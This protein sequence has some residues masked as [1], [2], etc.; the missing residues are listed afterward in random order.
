MPRKAPVR[1]RTARRLTAGKYL[2]RR[3]SSYVPTI[4]KRDGT[5]ACVP[6][7]IIRHVPALCRSAVGR[8]RARYCTGKDRTRRFFPFS[9]SRRPTATVSPQLETAT[10]VDAA[11]LFYLRLQQ[12]PIWKQLLASYPLLSRSGRNTFSRMSRATMSQSY[13]SATIAFA[14]ATTARTFSE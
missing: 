12:T 11:W 7:A 1:N 10:F 5:R 9:L 14:V 8:Q 4:A 13:F 2:S 3:Q 6:S